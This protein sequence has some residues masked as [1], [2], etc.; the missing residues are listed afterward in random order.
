MKRE[1]EL[2]CQSLIRIGG[3]CANGKYSFS[4][5]HC[6]GSGD[7]GTELENLYMLMASIYNRLTFVSSRSAGSAK[8]GHLGS[9]G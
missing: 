2:Q 9:L 3:E 6:T 4:L 5:N 8:L 1:A 7:A